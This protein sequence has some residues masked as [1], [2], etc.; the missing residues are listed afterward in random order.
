MCHFPGDSEL[1][2]N[3]S[4]SSADTDGDTDSSQVQTS[5]DSDA[6]AVESDGAEEADP[7]SSTKRLQDLSEDDY[8]EPAEPR[9]DV[10]ELVQYVCL[11]CVLVVVSTLSLKQ[12]DCGQP[13]SR[14]S[15]W[16]FNNNLHAQSYSA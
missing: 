8:E 6:A 4:S 5:A 11:L 13:L 10:D 12:C 14:T 9:I 16:V 7:L 3:S 2:K 1:A 15:T